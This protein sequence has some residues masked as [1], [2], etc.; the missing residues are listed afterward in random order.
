MNPKA[1][2]SKTKKILSLLGLLGLSAA[3]TQAV[4]RQWSG[5]TASY[6]TPGGWT[7][8][9]VPGGGDNAINNSGAA[10][11]V[12]ISAADPNWTVNDIRSGDGGGN[13][14][15]WL[16]SGANVTLNGW[17][18]IGI[19]T[20]IGSYT[21]SGGTMTVNAA[22]FNVG[23]GGTA[24][25]NMTGGTITKNGGGD[26]AIP[27]GG[28]GVMNQTNGT[29]NVA[30]G[31]FWVG[32]GTGAN[33]TY[34]L[35]SNGVMTVN[36]WVAIG[37]GGGTGVVNLSDNA[38]V[39]K[40]GANSFIVG[41]AGSGTW[42]QNG[43][44]V[45]NNTT[46]TW[47]GESG[48][49]IWN[50]N[51]GNVYLANIIFG[52]NGG[53]SGTFNLNGGTF[54][55]NQIS[56][57]AGS[58]ALN[59]NGGTLR[60]LAVNANFMSGVPGSL[61]AGGAVIDSQGF[62]VGISSVL[63]DG[64][65]GGL[66]KIGTGTL[67]LSGA[68]SYV[69]ATIVSAGKLIETTASLVTSA[70]TVANTAGAGVNVLVANGQVSHGN[71]TL[72]GAANTLNFDLGN[73]G[74]PT[75]APLNVTATLN[76]NGTT[77]VNVADA[78]PVVG[79]FPLIKYVTKTGAG[80]FVLG[81]LPTGVSATIVNNTGNNSI[82]LNI[83]STALIRWDGRVAGGVWDINTTTNWTDYIT[84]VAAKFNTGTAVFFD[85]VALGT[86]TANLGVAV[87]PSSVTVTNDALA[88]TITGVG[89]INGATGLTKQGSNTL[90]I[91]T[92]NGYTGATVISG[93]RVSITKLA[94][95]GSP[96]AIGTAASFTL[97]GGTLS[98]SGPALTTD[99]G[100]SLTRSSTL[101]AQ[102]DMTF[103]ST[104]SLTAGA[105]FSK[106][107]NGTLSVKRAGA[108]TLSL[109]GGGGAY[110]IV[111]GTVVMDG[112]AGAQVNSITGELWAGATTN[113]TG[114]NLILTNTTL[115]LSS[116]LAI[117]RG[118]GTGG[119]TSSVSL[120]NS[121]LKS[122][123]MSMTF[124]AGVA[125]TL[126]TGILTMN[127]TCTFTNNGDS[128]IGESTGGNAVINMKDSSVFF[129][130]GRMQIGWHSGA[131]GTVTVANSAKIVVNAWMSIGNE[132]G[133]GSVVVKDSGSIYCG[134]LNVC[135]V[136]SGQ[137]DLTVMNSAV[138]RANAVFVGKGATSVGTLT[139]IGGTVSGQNDGGAYVEI[140][141]SGLAT[142]TYNLNGGTLLA[143]RIRSVNNSATSTI[144]F[145]GG[146]LVAS[147]DGGQGVD[148]DFLN[149]LSAA[150]ILLGGLPLNTGT[151]N[152][153]VGQSLLGDVNGDGGLTKSGTGALL[154][155][156]INTYTN[157]TIA[158]AGTLGGSGTIAGPVTVQAA[159]T[160]APS[161]GN[162]IVT[163]T[164][165]NNLTIAGNLLFA[166]NGTNTPATNDQ[167]VV[168]G[169]L[170]K[171]GAGT[172]K[173][174]N[175][176]P[177]LSVGD[178]F[179]L[180]SQPLAGGSG[181]TVSGGGAT[182]VNNLQ[183]SGS[184]TVA[185]IIPP[186]SFTT[187]G[188]TRLPDGNIS[189]TATGTVGGTYKLWATSDLTLKPIAS[190]WTLLT[191]GTITTSPFTITDLNA[192][193]FTQR[194]YIFSAP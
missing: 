169:T 167:V 175:L 81:T 125:G 17:F 152:I 172:L 75:L 60:A 45:T 50:L 132:A 136:N 182:W 154:L 12:L 145:G 11:T 166:V 26:F 165:N 56:S 155:N 93:G 170:T 130:N 171:T 86:T 29:L 33:G 146:Q 160:L 8:G 128:N 88:Y 103:N 159:A 22:R 67:T 190:T 48:T 163:L 110:N 194:F 144:N 139:Q 177:A 102:S 105:N 18:R 21:M 106:T 191:S 64:A 183:T 148:A 178:T 115:N 32:Q 174:V 51:V 111:N 186:P 192:T 158:T 13:S 85:D 98:Y 100:Y 92:T 122:V 25:F 72:S 164:V 62:N 112:S 16:Q 133:V 35:S 43:G 101:D 119:Y 141:S 37:R 173:V 116:W 96:S 151:N 77:T 187:G 109:G 91:A 68:N 3:S 184:I 180:F 84:T 58:S 150:N 140:G 57:G 44:A 31:E 90:T 124:D 157:A 6:N 69:G 131:T 10:N 9:V 27:D 134:D 121:A 153:A 107:G 23:E 15:P 168:T 193:N 104:L 74:N 73:F 83:T 47:L 14:G 49:G 156:G 137:A 123:N 147:Q 129:S 63:A 5:G 142:G 4:D 82:D 36:N 118:T 138:A 1:Q 76:V 2:Y 59:F 108:N 127:D 87:L 79:Q 41:A 113:S 78:F 117:A 176:G 99:R 89:S 38:S 39:T 114:G 46:V 80:S 181:V 126:Q 189:L 161:R 185:S 188:T 34:N 135:D 95:S 53:S 24:T 40:A 70:L 97:D 30:S 52:L 66:T 120:Y 143:R 65:G 20:G 55:A 71:V 19:G 162:G 94:N 54:A 61:L 28:T 149:N 179:T 7:G 42:N